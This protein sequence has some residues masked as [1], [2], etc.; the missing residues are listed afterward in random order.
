MEIY[1]GQQEEVQYRVEN[2]CKEVVLR[3][4]KPISKTGRNVTCD[5][6]FYIGTPC[7]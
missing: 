3:L 4:I 6:W 2:S 5:N 7:S 1:R